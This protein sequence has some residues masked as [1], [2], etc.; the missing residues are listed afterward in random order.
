MNETVITK[1]A[2]QG[3][4]GLLLAISIF[5]IIFL[6]KEAK[7]ERVDRLT[8]MKDVWQKDVEY[9]AEI[10]NLIQNILDIIKL[11]K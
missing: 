5:G 10:K 8:D 1:L 3:L 7:K 9:R 2:E 4:L 6:Y 11:K